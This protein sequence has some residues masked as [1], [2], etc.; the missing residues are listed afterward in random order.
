MESHDAGQQRP[1]FWLTMDAAVYCGIMNPLLRPASLTRNLGSPL[2]PE[3]SLKILLS[4][5]F[6]SSDIAIARVSIGIA[7]GSPWKFPA[8]MIMSSSGKTLGL[9]VALLI[10]FSMTDWT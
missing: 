2:C 1:L 3:I 7:M 4:E 8:E 5:M 6:A 10:S 9:S